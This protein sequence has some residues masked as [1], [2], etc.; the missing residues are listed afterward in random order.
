[1]ARFGA[2]EHIED[3]EIDRGDCS[4]MKSFRKICVPAILFAAW[5]GMVPPANA[6]VGDCIQGSDWGTP[7][8]DL[9]SRVVELVNEHRAS[10]GLIQVQATPTLTNSGLWKSRHMAGYGYFT[11]SDPAPPVARSV[12]DRLL[13]CGYPSDRYGWGENIAYGHSTADSVMQAWLNSSGHRANIE[14]PGF[15]AIGVG[16]AANST[17]RIYWTQEFGTLV[18]TSTSPPAPA[19]SNGKDDDSDG[20]IDYPGDPGCSASSDNDEYNALT[21]GTAS[22][23][24]VTV[25]TGTVQSGGYANLRADDNS[26]FRVNSSSRATSWYGRMTG[27][28]NSLSSLSVTYKGMNSATCSQSVG[29]W[30]WSSGAW[31]WLDSRSVGTTEAGITVSPG[32][33]LAGYVSGSSGNGDVAVIVRCSA[34]VNFSASADLLQIKFSAP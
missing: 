33:T 21:T 24:S 10:K 16:A 15:R 34:G 31:V 6:L 25:S 13:A 14:N 7:R 19:C 17:G 11:H 9:T 22:P 27:V 8:Q 23:N 3:R 28:P 32:G 29:I 18:Q 1:M 12:A 26:F 5:A 20:R 4:V 30:N 2:E